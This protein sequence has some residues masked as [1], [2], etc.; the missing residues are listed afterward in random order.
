M[1]LHVYLPPRYDDFQMR[2]PV[3]VLLHPWGED[4]RFWTGRLQFHDLADHLINAGSVPPF[5]AA[6]PQGDKSFFVDAADPQDD[7]SSLIKLDPE[8]YA[9]AL[10]G[11]GK[12][13]EHILYD[14]LAYVE[15]NFRVRAGRS[16]LSIGGL[17]MG[18][19]G[20]AVLAF[21]SS[22]KF[23]AVGV[24]SPAL[25]DEWHSGPPWIFGLGDKEA[26]A[27][28]DPVSLA[29]S[30]SVDSGLRIYV[31]CGTEDEMSDPTADLHWAL[32]ECAIPHTYV[33]Q[34]GQGDTA[35][36]QAHLAEYLGFYA[37]GW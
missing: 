14:V 28:R 21:Q 10:E 18:A 16:G 34:P 6:F 8:T 11:Y 4:E 26:F 9:G 3:V 24:H 35:Y 31:D 37:G 20:A 17:G 1:R 36:W 15:K 33:S 23:G 12:Y 19:A 13:G 25:F 32:V 30:L 7:F 29:R 22:E 2:Y 5:I 27:R